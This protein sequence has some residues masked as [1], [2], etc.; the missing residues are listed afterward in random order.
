MSNC[1]TVEKRDVLRRHLS[2]L[3]EDELRFLVTRQL[4]LVSEQDPWAQDKQFLQVG[5]EGMRLKGGR[6]MRLGV[7]MGRGWGRGG[8][9]LGGGCACPWWKVQANRSPGSFMIFP[10]IPIHTPSILRRSPWPPTSAAAS[11]AR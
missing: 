7:R 8:G 5:G 11:N 6:G 4:R 3:S 1:G 2:A 10:L 9:R